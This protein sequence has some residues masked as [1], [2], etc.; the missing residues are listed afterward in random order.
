M[1]PHLPVYWDRPPLSSSATADQLKHCFTFNDET[2]EERTRARRKA[3]AMKMFALLNRK[4]YRELF[5]LSSSVIIWSCPVRIL[6]V[7]ITRV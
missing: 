6:H 2:I 4:S 7:P 3:F 5:S 1:G